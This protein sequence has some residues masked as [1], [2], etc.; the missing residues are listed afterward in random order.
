MLVL[1]VITLLNA[2]GAVGGGDPVHVVVECDDEVDGADGV[3]L[4]YVNVQ[5]DD[6]A[7]VDGAG[8]GDGDMMVFR[9][10][11]SVM[12]LLMLMLLMLKM[13]SVANL[14][15]L[16]VRMLMVLV[17]MLVLS[18]MILVRLMLTVLVVNRLLDFSASKQWSG[19]AQDGQ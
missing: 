8:G 18:L 9:F 3:D 6:V 15:T 4:V 10:V 7:D 12:M 17:V 13:L 5:C 19:S 16:M 2:D 1:S 11:L 14:M